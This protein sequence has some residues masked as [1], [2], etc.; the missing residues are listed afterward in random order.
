MAGGGSVKNRANVPKCQFFV[1]NGQAQP[2]SSRQVFPLVFKRCAGSSN[3]RRLVC[4]P[5]CGRECRRSR[6]VNS[7]TT[8]KRV[9]Y[10]GEV[11][12]KCHWR[13]HMLPQNSYNFFI[14]GYISFTRRTGQPQS[15]QRSSEGET[16]RLPAVLLAASTFA[17]LRATTLAQT[18]TPCSIVRCVG[19]TGP[20]VDAGL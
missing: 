8:R 9:A 4:A 2:R 19:A 10:F 5:R 16:M 20:V 15:C 14:Y 1:P 18:P 3:L 17:V 6:G 11:I 13:R 12:L 7:D